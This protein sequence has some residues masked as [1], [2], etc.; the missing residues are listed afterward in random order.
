[1]PRTKVNGV[2]IVSDTIDS[3]LIKQGSVSRSDLNTTTVGQAVVA[4]IVQGTGITIISSGAD[5]GTGD[6]TISATSANSLTESMIIAYAIV[7]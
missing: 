4:K 5:S 7:L 2:Q 6:V 3:D 1:M